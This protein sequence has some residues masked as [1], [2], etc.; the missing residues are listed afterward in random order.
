M[1]STPRWAVDPMDPQDADDDVAD[2]VV[3]WIA[4]HWSGG[5][6]DE[7]GIYSAQIDYDMF[8][9]ILGLTGQP[10]G[11]LVP[12]ESPVPDIASHDWAPDG[13]SLVYRS[14]GGIRGDGLWVVDDVS[15]P[16]GTT[17]NL[18]LD[19]HDPVWSPDGTKIAFKSSSTSPQFS[20]FTIN[21]DGSGQSY[22]VA[23]PILDRPPNLRCRAKQFL[24]A[25]DI[26]KRFV[27]R[28]RLDER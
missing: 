7:G 15:D 28:D 27:D 14:A 13:I 25:R 2:G 19:R 17:R 12:G 24:A 22:F 9:D 3:S 20:I 23:N 16:E 10:S 1:G 5:S 21:P 6:V 18:T 26:Q 4:R 11:P 8:G